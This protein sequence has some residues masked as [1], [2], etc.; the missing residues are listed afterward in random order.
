MRF[1]RVARRIELEGDVQLSIQKNRAPGKRSDRSSSFSLLPSGEMYSGVPTRLR[2][3]FCRWD[4]YAE[5]AMPKVHTYAAV[6]ANMMY[7]GFRSR[8]IHDFTVRGSRARQVAGLSWRLLSGGNFPFFSQHPTQV[9]PLQ[10]FRG[11]EIWKPSAWPRSKMRTDE[12]AVLSLRARI[13]LD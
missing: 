1:Q 10:I 12:V 4:D 9:L 13:A 8:C 11:C 2:F 6:R 3:A 5:R 7:F